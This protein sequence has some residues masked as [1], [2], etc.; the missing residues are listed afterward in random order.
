MGVAVDLSADKDSRSNVVILDVGELVSCITL[1]S[2]SL[3][4]ESAVVPA[5]AK[6]VKQRSM[7]PK[8]ERK[9]TRNNDL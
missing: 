5:K 4:K 9:E 7:T 3:I 2:A 8:Q 6:G 1:F